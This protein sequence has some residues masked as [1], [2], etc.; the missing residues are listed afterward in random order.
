LHWPYRNALQ[1]TR[2]WSHV[3]VD[4]DPHEQLQQRWSQMPSLHP[5]EHLE[6]DALQSTMYRYPPPHQE[7]SADFHQP[8]ANDPGGQA[9]TPLLMVQQNTV[10]P[11]EAV[12]P[13]PQIVA[14]AGTGRSTYSRGLVAS[15]DPATAAPRSRLRRLSGRNIVAIEPT[16][17]ARPPGPAL[18]SS[19]VLT[20]DPPDAGV[21]PGR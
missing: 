4:P 10:H 9:L 7:E 5:V 20:G 6:H 12:L 11:L 21:W 13:G 3:A 19:S 17:P 14:Y 2:R 18:R 1:Q 15:A 16:R 8:A